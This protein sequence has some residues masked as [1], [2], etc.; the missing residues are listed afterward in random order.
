MVQNSLTLT[1]QFV[2][3]R[4][5][6]G[7]STLLIR[8][9]GTPVSAEAGT[10][11]AVQCVLWETRSQADAFLADPV[12]AIETTDAEV[13]HVGEVIS[14]DGLGHAV[15]KAS[16]P[17]SALVTGII[18]FLPA[19]GKQAW[20]DEYNR[21]E[22]RDYIQY[23]SGFVSASFLFADRDQRLTELVQW[24]S[25]DAFQAAFRDERFGEH[26]NVANH[27]STSEVGT[28]RVHRTID[29]ASCAAKDPERKR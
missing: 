10:Q 29:R 19:A 23:L 1:Q 3:S 4:A 27:Y 17:S 5:G 21:S 26:I 8:E 13:Y 6:F 22:T 24:S 16:D 25:M 18:T 15:I 20:I 9:P 14:V 2:A 12:S 7:G 11:R 28:Y